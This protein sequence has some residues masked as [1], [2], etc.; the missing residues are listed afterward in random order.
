M[1]SPS[2]L[3][4]AA[5]NC[6]PFGLGQGDRSWFHDI[7]HG[8]IAKGIGT[9]DRIEKEHEANQRSV[10]GRGGIAFGEQ[11]VSI[12]FGINWRDL[13]GFEAWMF[14]LQPSGKATCILGI[15]CDGFGR[16]VRAKV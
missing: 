5:P 2:G 3:F 11:L 12:G 4:S 7:D 13:G 16:Q 10:D 15:E 14:L 8:Q 9:I 6:I 1:I